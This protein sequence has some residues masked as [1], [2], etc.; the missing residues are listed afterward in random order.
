MINISIV[1]GEVIKLLVHIA[2]LST[3]S[4]TSAIAGA[5]LECYPNPAVSGRDEVKI[6]IQPTADGTVTIEIY[7]IDGYFVIR[8]LSDEPVK[9][10]DS[11]IVTRW[12][13]RNGE[14]AAVKPGA[15]V[16]KL[17]GTFGDE[18]VTERFVLIAEI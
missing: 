6:A 12:D 2:V 7:A 16:V 17:T 4:V 9:A 13:M 1:K 15:Y 14:G 11:Y 8:L 18:S 10:G 3:V 5:G